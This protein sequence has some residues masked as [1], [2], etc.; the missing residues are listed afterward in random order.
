MTWEFNLTWL[1]K[2]HRDIQEN[3][4]VNDEKHTEMNGCKK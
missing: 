1:F 3:T 2:S 4:R